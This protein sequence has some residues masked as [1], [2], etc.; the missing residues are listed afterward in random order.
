MLGNNQILFN[1][2]LFSNIP[3]EASI[4]ASIFYP[5]APHISGKVG[6]GEQKNFCFSRSFD[7]SLLHTFKLSIFPRPYKNAEFG[8]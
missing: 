1:V 7:A 2:E 8:K 5:T 3:L 4:E 6:G